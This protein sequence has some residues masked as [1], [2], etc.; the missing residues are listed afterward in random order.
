MKLFRNYLEATLAVF[1]CIL[2]GSAFAQEPSWWIEK[3]IGNT[4]SDNQANFNAANVGQLKYI[5]KRAAEVLDSKLSDSGGAGPEISNMVNSFSGFDPSAPDE[6]Y[7]I[8]NIGQLK[9]V[10]K[11]F[12]D[13]L[14][15]LG[16]DKIRYPHGMELISGG[17]DSSSNKYPWPAISANPSAEEISE[18][19]KAALVGQLK[20]LFSWDVLENSGFSYDGIGNGWYNNFAGEYSQELGDICPLII[21]PIGSTYITGESV[22]VKV[23]V[24][25]ARGNAIKNA[26]VK[27]YAPDD[28]SASLSSLSAFS[29]PDGSASITASLAQNCDYAMVVAY[30]DGSQDQKC[31][32][33]ISR[34]SQPVPG[35]EESVMFTYMGIDSDRFVN[36]GL[37]VGEFDSIGSLA[38]NLEPKTILYGYNVEETYS[39]NED[40]EEYTY[41]QLKNEMPHIVVGYGTYPTKMV[42]ETGW[43]LP[44]DPDYDYQSPTGEVLVGYK[45]SISAN[46]GDF[47]PSLKPNLRRSGM[48]CDTRV[49]V[50]STTNGFYKEVYF[51]YSPWISNISVN[52]YQSATIKVSAPR[53]LITEYCDEISVSGGFSAVLEG[54]RIIISPPSSGTATGVLTL[55][56]NYSKEGAWSD[57]MSVSYNLEAG[58]ADGGFSVNVTEF[59]SQKYRK[60]AFNGRPLADE[61]P[62][63]DPES[64]S[65]KAESYIDAFTQSL[66]YDVLDAYIPLQNTDLSLSVRRNY[67]SA[68]WRIV[69]GLRPSEN[70]AEPFGENWSTNLCSYA[71]MEIVSAGNKT[72]PDTI[73][74]YDENGMPFVFGIV[75]SGNSISKA[76]PMP[77]NKADVQAFLNTLE[78]S[79]DESTIVFKKRYGTKIT[80]SKITSYNGLHINRAFANNNQTYDLIFYRAEEVEDRFGNKLEYDYTR[81]YGGPPL[82]IPTK[83]TYVPL[84][85]STLEMYIST[86]SNGKICMVRLPNGEKIFYEYTQYAYMGNSPTEIEF[87][88]YVFNSSYQTLSRV[89]VTTIDD[90][91]ISLT[92]YGYELSFEHEI[93]GLYN[94]SSNRYDYNHIHIDLVSIDNNLDN[95]ITFSYEPFP[96]SLDDPAVKSGVL[97]NINGFY[98]APSGGPRKV[99]RV[100]FPDGKYS[101]F[102]G[103]SSVYLRTMPNY[104]NRYTPSALDSQRSSRKIRIRDTEGNFTA[105]TWFDNRA[106]SEF[107]EIDGQKLESFSDNYG[108]SAGYYFDSPLIVYY[109]KMRIEYFDA[110]NP[111]VAVASEIY[112]FDID[113]GMALKKSTDI[114][115]NV[116]QFE[117]ADAI[118][119]DILSDSDL[120]YSYSARWNIS[121]TYGRPKYPE[122]TKQTNALGKVRTFTYSPHYRIMSSSTD[123]LGNKTEWAVDNLGRRTAEIL[124]DSSNNIVRK[125]TYEYSNAAFKSF[126][127]KET[128]EDGAG[129][130]ADIV[131]EYQAD[132]LGRLSKEIRHNAG[133]EYTIEY[134]YNLNCRKI[135]QSDSDGATF[136]WV[137][138]YANRLAEK[139]FPDGSHISYAYDARGRKISETLNFE[140]LREYTYD[141]RDNLIQTKISPISGDEYTVTSSAYDGCNNIIASVDANG[142]WTTYSY[143]CI[144]RPVSKKLY[145]TAG[146]DSGD[147]A[148]TQLFYGQNCGSSIFANDGF[149]PTKTI[150]S[151]GFETTFEYDSLYRL[152]KTQVEYSKNPS[153]KRTTTYAYDDVGNKVSETDSNG[154]TTLFEYDPMRNLTKTTY[155]DG[156]FKSAAYTSASLVLSETDELGNTVEYAYDAMG[157]I[158]SKTFPAVDIYGGAAPVNPIERYICDGRGNIVRKISPNGFGYD[159][160]YDGMNR[161][162]YEIAPAMSFEENGSVVYRRPT[163]STAYDFFGNAVR[164]TDPNGNEIEYF[165]DYMNRPVRVVY[166]NA[167]PAGDLQELNS[168]DA[169][170]NLTDFTDKA[171]RVTHTVYNYLN[172][173]VSVTRNYGESVSIT[174]TAEYDGEGNVTARVDGEGNRTEYTYDGL[175]RLT[176][177][178]YGVGGNAQRS[179]PYAYD[180]LNLVQDIGVSYDYDNRNRL[181]CADEIGMTDQVYQVEYIYN[182]TYDALGRVVHCQDVWNEYDSNGRLTSETSNGFEHRYQYDLNGNRMLAEYGYEF[183]EN[184]IYPFSIDC[185]HRQRFLYDANNRVISITDGDAR[186]TTYQYDL[187]GNIVKQTYPNGVE[188]LRQYDTF[189]RVTSIVAKKDSAVLQT[190]TYSYDAVGNVVE[191]VQES[192]SRRLEISNQYDAFDRLSKETR[193]ESSTPN[194]SLVNTYFYDS[195]NNIVEVVKTYDLISERTEYVYNSLNQ[196]ISMRSYD[197]NNEAIHTYTYTYNGKGCLNIVKKDGKSVAGY[198][199]NGFFHLVS[200]YT[201]DNSN[202]T[203][204]YYYDYRGRRISESPFFAEYYREYTY[205]GGTSVIEY[206]YSENSG[207]VSISENILYYRG[208]DMGGG[209]G[210][211]N[212][213][214]D[215]IDNS[216]NYKHYNLRGDVIMTT[217]SAGSVLSELWY[218]AYGEYEGFGVLPSDKYRANTKVD[219][220]ELILDG[221][222]YRN[223]ALMRFMSP[224]PLEYIDGLN[225][226]IYCSNNPWGRFDPDGLWGKNQPDSDFAKEFNQKLKGNLDPVSDI[227][228]TINLYIAALADSI[229]GGMISAFDNAVTNGQGVASRDEFKEVAENVSKAEFILGGGA[230]KKFGKDALKKSAEHIK[231]KKHTASKRFFDQLDDEEYIEISKSKIQKINRRGKNYGKMGEGHERANRQSKDSTRA[232]KLNLDK[233]MKKTFHDHITKKNLSYHELRE[234]ARHLKGEK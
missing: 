55:T 74:V 90:E 17:A 107:G 196:L 225:C 163:R 229:S 212:Y 133:G 192:Q 67:K 66:R 52:E 158:L 223:K 153:L 58:P 197:S 175:N 18:N 131:A 5:S 210:G 135:L 169:N 154:N 73:T 87:S 155:A 106:G 36:D 59:S 27:F 84:S 199:F 29:A 26:A 19:Y 143:D 170:G 110:D 48:E 25:D 79:E 54:N 56:N 105:Y 28:N 63:L 123:E 116:T 147:Y 156:N 44:L 188:I 181:I 168:Y 69:S 14:F 120:P 35:Y 189:N 220:G 23:M 92:N 6:N 98:Y 20:Y 178:S 43:Y 194:S 11:K 42:I 234:V 211:I 183:D 71:K 203:Q 159:Y 160:V 209:V 171:G 139:I 89:R 186:I 140:V 157:H 138:D 184:S 108:S 201:N 10:A 109:P 128:I 111:S 165:Y 126:I 102:I 161:L 164:K 1:A 96:S 204:R 119:D 64:D 219:D 145:K 217:G 104:Q 146:S 77:S 174:E 75:Y 224:D 57:K 136:A 232:E 207:N 191:L 62:Q 190:N 214:C 230:A 13:R 40:F 202:I 32:F 65:I 121:S 112:E 118:I 205:S 141:C 218:T 9:Y 51:Y 151:N 53:Q 180:A 39:N 167:V 216:I 124:Y 12:Y 185:T 21:E 70:P 46:Y 206:E 3:G 37:M 137:Y 8:A 179:R 68:S 101:E 114:N 117:Y 125:T 233:G 60:V 132:A 162:V 45:E 91:D 47:V 72:S 144:G 149:K 41:S 150:D 142:F 226:Y 222:R 4:P 49:Y 231:V 215:L 134:A 182:Y 127:T 166:K 200:F 130:G 15:E 193:I 94:P 83:I 195:A 81:M 22:Q 122:A 187:N 129:A 198:S 61:K 99:S 7:K 97:S 78:I 213:A 16:T 115:G 31:T 103:D 85:G 173:P 76:Y 172:K 176:L 152:T 80:Y 100:T 148:Q 82:L 34:A 95:T 24:K 86:D 2:L 33:T 228:D 50:G 30:L 208:P 113:A 227:L 221:H 177:A 38:Y 88:Q 93:I